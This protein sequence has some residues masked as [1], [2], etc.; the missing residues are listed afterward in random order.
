MIFFGFMGFDLLEVL[1]EDKDFVCIFARLV[2]KK[3]QEKKR[4]SFVFVVTSC[5]V[6]LLREW[7]KEPFRYLS[8]T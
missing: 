1:V 7:G 2:A 4:K 8:L 5:C 3:M 6:W